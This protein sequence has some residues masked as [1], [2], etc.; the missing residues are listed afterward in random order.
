MNIGE[1]FLSEIKKIKIG[2]EISNKIIY[3][4][5]FL[6]EFRVKNTYFTR[7]Q[8]SKM[9]FNDVILFIKLCKKK[10]TN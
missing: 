3:D 6:Y 4:I 5:M 10:F 8:D 9:K 7:R 2:I 1:I